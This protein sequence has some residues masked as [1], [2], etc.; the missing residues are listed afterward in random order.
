MHENVITSNYTVQ[1]L[2]F[3]N[4]KSALF[5]RSHIKYTAVTKDTGESDL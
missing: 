4:I 2:P 5:P 1:I 3:E